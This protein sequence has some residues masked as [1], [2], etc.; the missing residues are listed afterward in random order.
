[1]F[2]PIGW[3][4]VL[5]STEPEKIRAVVCNRDKIL[6]AILTTDALAIWYCKPCVPIVFIR[7]PV[8]SINKYGDNI[9]V[10]WR[11]DSSMLVVAT[12]DSYLLFYR[13]SYNGPDAHGLYEQRDSPVTSLRRDS[14]ELFIKEVIP[15]LTLNFEKSAWIDGGISSLVCIRDELM[16]AT[17]TSHVVRQK[18]DGT[19]NR[20]YSLDLRRIPFS[21]DQQISTVAVPITENNVYVLD[22]EYSPLVGGFAI[23]LSNGKAAF[24]TAQS[25][26]FDPNQVQGIWARDLDDATCAAVNHKY[27]LIACGRR[28]SEGVVY[29]VD[30]TT[31]A[32]EVSHSL[33]LSSKDYPGKPGQV[34]CL[35]W[36]PDSCAIGMTWEGGGLAIWSTFGALLLCSL[37]WD[38]GLR[39]DLAR[40]N[41]LHIHTMEWSAEG[42][43]L[44][45]LRESPEPSMAEENGN[46]ITNTH[47]LIQMDFAKSPLTVN[48]CMGHHGHLYLQGEDR[49]YL[50]L[51]SGVSTHTGFH[52]ANEMPLDNS[53]QA[54]SSSKQWLVVPIPIAYSGSNWPIRFTAIDNEGLSIAVAG[55]TGL[56]HYSLPSR[57]WKLFGNETQERDFIVT[58]G[59]LWHRGFLIASSYSLLEDKDEIRIYPRDTRLD[60]TYVRSVKMPS[61]ILLLNSMKNHLLTFC[62]NAQISIYDMVLEGNEGTGS[63][64]LIRTQ[65]IDIGG[66]CVHPA[67][68]VSATLTT[69]RA[70]TAGSHPHPESLLLNVSG[71]LLMVQREHCTDNPEVLF[72]CGAPT[73][74]ASC[75]EN[76]WVPWRSRRDKPHLT[77]ALWLFCGAHGMRVWLPLFPRNHQDKA[78]TFMSK[79]IMLPFH[80]RI[81]PLAI[82]FEEAI[83]LG[84]E[85]DTVLYT[86]D[87]HSLFSLP[88]CLLELTSQVYLHQILRQLIHRNLGYHAWEIARSCS[89]L[90]YFPHSLELLLH[91]VLEEEA[92]S[93][94]PIPDAQLPSVVEFI[95]EFPGVWARAVVQ[96]ARKTEIALWPYL[97]SVAG[98][99]KKLLQDCLQRQE[100][101]TAA[102]YLIILQNLEPSAVSRQ[103]ATLLLDAALE[104]GR[105]ELSRDLVRFL[106]AI[107]PNDVESPRTSWGGSSKLGGPTQTPPLSPQEDDLSL[108]LGTMQ[109]S[110][111]RSYSTTVSPKVQSESGSKDS[112]P[113]SMLEKTRNVVM[114]RKKSVP[115]VKAEKSENKEGSAEEFFI[116]VILQRHAR[117]LLSARRLAD[118]GRFAARLDFHL[119][120]WLARERERAAKIDDFVAALKAVHEDF[121][122]PYPLLSLPSLNK[123]RRSSVTSLRSLRSTNF[124]TPEEILSPNIPL[125]VPDSGYTSLPSSRPPYTS[126]V[127]PVASLETQFPVTEANLT[128]HMLQDSNSVIS[129]T[130]TVWRDDIESI[131]GT[132][133]G[134]VCWVAPEPIEPAEL[135]VASPAGPVSRAEV[136]L[137]YL[138]QLFLEGGCLGWA[139]VL[140]TVLRDA[141]AMARTVR[142][143]YAPMQTLDSAI[144]LREGLHLMTR[145]SHSECLG[146]RSFTSGIQGQIS[147]LNR[148]IMTK[149]QQEQEQIPESPSPSPAPSAGSQPRGSISRSRHSSTSTTALEEERSVDSS[150]SVEETSFRGS[151]SSLKDLEENSQ[152]GCTIS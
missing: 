46:E 28:N 14:A 36:T 35:R 148:L 111:S 34:T 87:T 72:T 49:L 76:V 129:E 41:P 131:V 52:L 105:W 95:R 91:E 123:F 53:T 51:G 63:I 47:T 104:Q 33:S 142:A 84:A 137:R 107:D 92:T 113:S 135:H 67:C 149:Q 77:E 59:L 118:L 130:S 122:F 108:V 125:D 70:E 97:F 132:G 32:L 43:Q 30:E 68:V 102:S 73:V 146:Y 114:R 103:H 120:T 22:I 20:D 1:M 23:V 99:P 18:W 134:T 93:K 124:E 85:N 112:T 2:F 138:L 16:V 65:T 147:L 40:D 151:H 98:S 81:Y 58:G 127:S 44:W 54:L 3:P 7:R 45:M 139:A 110:R 56:A 126:L 106:R 136:Q 9:L 145:W 24:L 38:Y 150:T 69:I 119:V 31:G 78:H 50:N 6:F 25:L 61:Q 11:P 90:P 143:A 17:K 83:L 152:S 128:P 141:P 27:R 89:A 117:R 79:R 101:D 12:S 100:L 26:K 66:L 80:L 71:R 60:N 4:R 94:E 62:A 116:D 86:S 42:Y 39:V 144:N 75:V 109:V 15:S 96:C 64:E 48:P 82:L 88:F 21:V 37:K 121:I 57:K 74:L 133:V 10:Q 8:D 19:A 55:R 13:L 115:T 5:N 140:A 29:Y